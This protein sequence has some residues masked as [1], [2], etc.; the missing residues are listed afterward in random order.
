MTHKIEV[1]NITL[2]NGEPA[3]Q[4]FYSMTREQFEVFKNMTDEQL[5][6]FWRVLR[7]KISRKYYKALDDEIY[8]CFMNGDFSPNHSGQ[9]KGQ[10]NDNPESEGRIFRG[11]AGDESRES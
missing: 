11:I 3:I 9:T 7:D 4:V 6:Q 8:R 1:K 10:H 5:E 2:D